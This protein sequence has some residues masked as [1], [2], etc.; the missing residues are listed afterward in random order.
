MTQFVT[1]IDAVLAAAVDALVDA[2]VV[3]SRSDAVR[4]GLHDLVDRH[5]RAEVGRSI[6]AGYRAMPQSE[7][8]AVWAD[9]ATIAMIAEE[10]W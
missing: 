10:P 7:S 4:V 8:D 5:R 1:R 3:D 9:E 2:G 6:V